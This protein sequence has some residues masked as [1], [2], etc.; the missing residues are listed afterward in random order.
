MTIKVRIPSSLRTLTR[1]QALL[2]AQG[3]SVVEIIENIESKFPGIKA[4]LLD[5]QGKRRK[6]INLFVNGEN[7]RQLQAEATPLKDGDEL[8]ILPIIAGG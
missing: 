5:E 4:R 7:V 2:E 8:D 6:F 1:N 3:T